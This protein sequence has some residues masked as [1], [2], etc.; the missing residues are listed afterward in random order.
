MAYWNHFADFEY[1]RVL[2]SELKV[3]DLFRDYRFSGKRRRGF[4]VMIKVS[5]TEYMEQKSKE[6]HGFFNASL[7]NTAKVY[8]YGKRCSAGA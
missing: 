4:I 6:M 3:G 7:A 8:S 5:E 1:D 2:F